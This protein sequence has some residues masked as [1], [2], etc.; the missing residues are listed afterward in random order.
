LLMLISTNR[1]VVFDIIE[2]RYQNNAKRIHIVQLCVDMAWNQ[3]TIDMRS[4]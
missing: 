3:A 4:Y 1:K 2:Y